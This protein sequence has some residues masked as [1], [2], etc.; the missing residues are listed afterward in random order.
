MLGDI[1]FRR[2]RTKEYARDSVQ[3]FAWIR[4]PITAV[5]LLDLPALQWMYVGDECNLA[6]SGGWSIF[7][8]FPVD[9]RSAFTQHI[10]NA[11][12]P[13]ADILLFHEI[14]H[15]NL[16]VTVEPLP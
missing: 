2:S 3:W 15:R 11:P 13:I 6:S 7:I 14:P 12:D 5:T 4:Y 8:G 9:Y 10:A 16:G 1:P